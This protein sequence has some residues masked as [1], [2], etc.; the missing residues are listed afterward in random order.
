MY[1][2]VANVF[3]IAVPNIQ[4]GMLHQVRAAALHSCCYY[5]AC[6]LRKRAV[7]VQ[8]SLSIIGGYGSISGMRRSLGNRTA[9]H[10]APPPGA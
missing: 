1:S 7:Y 6:V 3:M 4:N 9:T 8:A 2:H 10:T 5:A